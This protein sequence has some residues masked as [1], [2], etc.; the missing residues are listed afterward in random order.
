MCALDDVSSLDE[1]AA[2]LKLTPAKVVELARTHKLAAIKE[3]RRW[4][5]PRAA[6]EAYI[7]SHTIQAKP[8]NPWGLTDG[9][10]SNLT[11]RPP[12][13]KS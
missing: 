6:I 2:Y 1:T 12:D 3:G 7:E 4:I 13:A 10:L 5:F 9:A 8:A 11:R